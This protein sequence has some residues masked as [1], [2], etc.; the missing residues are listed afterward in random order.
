[1]LSTPFWEF[2]TG[3]HPLDSGD[4]YGRHLSTPFWEFQYQNIKQLL[5]DV[6]ELSTPF[7]EFQEFEEFDILVRRINIFLLPFGSFILRA[8]VKIVE[9]ETR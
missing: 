9:E 6:E 4:L 3:A 1:L 8:I 7:W 5:R 2:H